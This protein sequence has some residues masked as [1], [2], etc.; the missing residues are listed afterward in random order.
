RNL[1]TRRDDGTAEASSTIN[2]SPVSVRIEQLR[3][4]PVHLR[5]VVHAR[6]VDMALARVYLPAE[7]PV[8]LERGRLDLTVN[9][10]HD[11]RDGVHVD[12]DAAVA[13]AAAV[14]RFQRD[15][16][17]RAPALRVAVRDFTYSDRGFALGRVELDGRA[18]VLH[19]DVDPPA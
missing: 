1:S 11:A 9:V 14:R 2:G 15:P 12:A 4:K 13:D 10:V 8:T 18:S 16:F 7:A 5:A 19:T 3:L 6:D 17:I